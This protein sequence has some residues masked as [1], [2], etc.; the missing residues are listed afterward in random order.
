MQG[1]KKWLRDLPV[2][3]KLFLFCTALLSFF[4]ILSITLVSATGYRFASERSNDSLVV[5]QR[6]FSQVL[7]Q[8]QDTLH[9]A[10]QVLAADFGF[11]EAMASND[12]ETIGSALQ[13][14]TSRIKASIAV[15]LDLNGKVV[16]STAPQLVA[17]DAA[18]F[19][20]LLVRAA[21]NG[22]TGGIAF[23][24]G[25][26][27]ELIIVPV[28]A[29]LNIGW[30][31]LGFALDDAALRKV[32]G[33]VSLDVSVLVKQKEGWRLQAS[34]LGGDPGRI[35]DFT[36]AAVSVGSEKIL[37]DMDGQ[38]YQLR[39]M[40]LQTVD[41]SQVVAVLQQSFATAVAPYQR[42]LMILIAVLFLSFLVATAGSRRLAK[43][44]SQPLVQ[45]TKKTQ[46]IA[47]GEYGQP[48][49]VSGLDEVG[50]LASSV[51]AMSDA[52]ALREKKIMHS[53]YYDALTQLPNRQMMN[54]L[55]DQALALA[56]RE[57]RTL[58]VI[59]MDVERFQ[60]I[61]DALGYAVGDEVLCAVAERL[62]TLVRDADAISRPG[63]NQF[64]TLM[65][66]PA[67]LNVSDL[68]RRMEEA[69]ALPIEVGGN[70]VDVSMAMGLS[71][72]PDHGSS[73][74]EL[75]RSADIALAVAKRERHG[76]VLYDPVLEQGRVAHLTL[77][78][79]LK[80]AVERDELVM[81][82]Q[83]KVNVLTGDVTSAEALVRWQHPER[84][85]VAPSEFIPFAE[86]SGRIGMLTQWMLGKA[87]QLTVLWAD[88]GT[89]IQVSVNVSA[90]DILDERFPG[91]LKELLALH[92]GRPEWLRL[93]ITESGVMENAERA[94]DVLKQI[95]NLGFSLSIDDFG[96]GY[97]SL[98]YLKR[99]P[100]AELKIDRS[101]VHGARAGTDAAV[102]LRSTIDLGH[103]L[104]LSVVAEGVETIEEWTLLHELGC[105]YIQGYM[106]CKP[107]AVDD[108][109]SWCLASSPF[110]PELAVSA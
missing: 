100:V 84:G 5:G 3:G 15:A 52:I 73:M 88:A 50:Q 42:L 71:L 47:K 76:I 32:A 49:Q 83:P 26:P 101:F 6:V 89:P 66:T 107:L 43:L 34:T 62:R 17:G 97:S 18:V 10:A 23:V 39:V 70:I 14:Q 67:R 85:F 21:Q 53:A 37:L 92:H 109:R 99:M 110:L 20:T 63:G 25:R 45:L 75:M 74:M 78:S 33:L 16:A 102:L 79:E 72:Y 96:T 61:N 35:E 12:A 77:L 28:K 87:M 30:V 1:L 106:A 51:N 4:L 56:Q 22:D 8:Q 38:K 27:L 36:L 13:S 59:A 29:P 46:A 108:F 94:L 93:E 44:F 48:L 55:G 60:L 68:H 90:R 86:Q 9:Q 69:F 24:D 103:N 31:V 11:R 58:A 19:S 54:I 104:A 98:S 41:G 65:H 82:L 2:G 95:R 40:P 57:H 80:R 81:Y 7:T 91:T 64:I 105:D